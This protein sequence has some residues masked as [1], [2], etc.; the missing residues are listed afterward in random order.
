MTPELYE[1]YRAAAESL[2]LAESLS[3]DA[4]IAGVSPAVQRKDMELASV[5]ADEVRGDTAY[6]DAEM[7]AGGKTT[8]E[9]LVLKRD[10]STWR[11]AGKQ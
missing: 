3:A 7:R 2:K 11:I 9:R 4:G 10:G 6:V 5:R 1:Q 8:F